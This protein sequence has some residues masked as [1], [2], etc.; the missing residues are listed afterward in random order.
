MAS[1][2]ELK[3]IWKSL[4]ILGGLVIGGFFLW[5]TNGLVKELRIQER[6]KVALWAEATKE[7]GN[8]EDPDAD[9]NFLMQVISLNKT[10]PVIVMDENG[11]ITQ[12]RNLDSKKRDNEAYMKKMVDEMEAEHEPIVIEYYGDQKMIIY[13]KD[14]TILTQLQYFPILLFIVVA[15][16]IL[17]SYIAFS[18]SRKAQQNLVW[19]GMARETAHQIGT[20]LSS[21]MGWQ[22]ILKGYNVDSYVTDEIDKDIKR[23]QT[24]TERFSKIGSMPELSAMDVIEVTQHASKYINDRSSKKIQF[25]FE[26]PEVAEI[27]L[28]INVQLY[29]WVIE[30]LMRNAI[31][32]MNGSGHIAIK[33]T[34]LSHKVHIDVSDTGKGIK[35]TMFKTIFQPGYTT[36]KR[37]WGLG[38]SLVKRIIEEYHNGEVFVL[39]SNAKDGTTFRITMQK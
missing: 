22:E 16:F 10:V 13:Y 8:I 21:L 38:L 3:K 14:S 28:P 23:L 11:N 18:N 2:Y 9:I 19:A 35:S 4:I 5:Y 37:G 1:A 29:E 20:P 34:E 24:I 36:K 31:D 33:I 27:I 15:M 17:I 32:A 7:A 6:E 26:A 12:D 39:R 25:T 30:N